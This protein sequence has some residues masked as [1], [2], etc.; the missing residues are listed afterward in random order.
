MVIAK[1]K[2]VMLVETCLCCLAHGRPAHAVFA[3]CEVLTHGT[4]QNDS[5]NEFD[6]GYD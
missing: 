5:A 3:H 2:K 1:I 6:S 4:R